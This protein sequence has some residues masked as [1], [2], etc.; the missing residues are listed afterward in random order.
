MRREI[1][2]ESAFIQ[3]EESTH[4]F[5]VHYGNSSYSDMKM[6]VFNYL[7]PRGPIRTVSSVIK[8]DIPPHT[9]QNSYSP[10]DNPLTLAS[11]PI[12]I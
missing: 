3:N 2:E 6:L 10:M 1:G 11:N 8:N 9:S 12:Y 5:F 4:D 7:L